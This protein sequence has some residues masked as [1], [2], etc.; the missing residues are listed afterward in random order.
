MKKKILIIFGGQST[1]HDVSC[2][3][4]V[5]VIRSLDRDRYIPVII[6]ITKNGEWLSVDS[7]MDIL[8]GSWEFGRRRAIFSP[9]AG[10]RSVIFFDDESG[11]I[12]KTR[13]DCAFPVLHG[14]FGEDGTIQGLFELARLPYVGAGVLSSSICMDKAFTKI[15]AG[16]IGVRQ[17]SF[18]LLTDNEI[19]DAEF[20]VGKV[21]SAFRYPVF[22]KPSNAGS[23][24]GVT[25]AADRGELIEALSK[26]GEIDRKIL[27]EE[28]IIGRE[29][30]CAVFGGGGDEVVSL[31]F[32]EV[33]SA[34]EF[35]DYDSKYNNPESK[36]TV[37]PQLPE[38][39]AEELQKTA[40]AVYKAVDCSGMARADFFVTESGE[41]IFNEINTIPGFTNISMYPKIAEASGIEYKTL[42]TMLIENGM[43]RYG[44][45]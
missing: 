26:A 10:D 4:A 27:V 15:I 37:T 42:I 39:A 19:S 38:G 5:N 24:C 7:D 6:G 21:E 43:K 13:V 1:E 14:K 30:E 40:I 36:T 11:E 23:S 17:A 22:V 16:N 45:E 9:D 33:K 28:T 8:D 18:V 2:S 20:A 34:S 44:G 32:G 41:I 12:V 3:S 25:K 29:I 35:Y 31:G